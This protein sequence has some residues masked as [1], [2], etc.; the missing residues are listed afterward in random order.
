MDII[1]PYPYPLSGFI[2]T[3]NLARSI[4]DSWRNWPVSGLFYNVNLI[5]ICFEKPIRH[6]YN[7]FLLTPLINLLY[8]AGVEKV[9]N[10][11]Y[12]IFMSDIL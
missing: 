2:I 10:L 11:P 5:S 12:G 9:I 4:N 6:K 7:E 8:K 1:K 3:S